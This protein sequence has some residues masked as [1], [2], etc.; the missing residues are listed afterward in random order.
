[1]NI[2]EV[3]LEVLHDYQQART[4]KFKNNIL[5]NKI[6]SNHLECFKYLLR[7][8]GDRYSIQGSPGIGQW[9]DCPWFGIFDTIKTESAQHG[10]Y[11]VYL[12]D[13]KMN[14]VY[15]SLNQ[16]V[17]D[18]KNEYK[19]EAKKVLSSRAEDFRS[20]LDFLHED[21]INISLNSTLS[22][23]I[24]YE[25]GN[26]LAVYYDVTNIP[27]EKILEE[28]LRRFLKYYQSL[29][30]LDF[31]TINYSKNNCTIEEIKKKQLQ[32]KF[33]RRGEVSL[34]VKKKKGYTCEACGFS[35]ENKY[36]EIG[37]NFIEVHHLIPFASLKEGNTSLNL[38]K[39]FAVLCSNC[40]RMI[41]KLKDPSNLEQLK[42]IVQKYY[43]DG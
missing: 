33:D 26:I 42:T 20:K 23:P 13:S 14:G 10:Y 3:L 39:D 21:K 40:H 36:G 18:V 4:Y 30:M 38:E 17:T 8:Y 24:L 15:L 29:I 9:A 22:N 28:D 6:R 5:A 12:F 31:S 1:M 43:I 27:N 7:N 32:E 11:I 25:R 19:N 37:K 2:R 35:F 41:H 34:A 16:G